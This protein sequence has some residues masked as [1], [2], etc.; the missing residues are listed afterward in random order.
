LQLGFRDGFPGL[1][2]AAMGAF[3]VFL[4]YLKLWEL[5]RLGD[6]EA[7]RAKSSYAGDPARAEARATGG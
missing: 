3:A 7:E 5:H 4:K 6:V 2:N 1:I